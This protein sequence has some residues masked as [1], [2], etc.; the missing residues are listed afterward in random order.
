MPKRAEF[1]RSFAKIADWYER[2]GH[3]VNDPRVQAQ[4]AAESYVE[5]NRAILMNDNMVTTG[6]TAILNHFKRQDNA[7]AAAF[8]LMTEVEFPIVKVATNFADEVA[9]YTAGGLRAIP[10]LTKAALKGIDA[11]SPKEADFIMRNLKKN[12]LSA[13]LASAVFS[14]VLKITFAGNYQRGEKRDSTE[15]KAGEWAINGVKMPTAIGHIPIFESMQVYQTAFNAAEASRL[16]GDSQAANITAGIGQGA[17]SDLEHIPFVGTTTKDAESFATPEGRQKWFTKLTVSLLVPP[18]SSSVAR[19][20]DNDTPRQPR[21]SKEL[22]EN[23]IPGVRQNIPI[24]EGKVKGEIIDRMRKGLDLTEYQQ[25]L[26]DSMSVEKQDSIE[27]ESQLTPRQAAF[28][29]EKSIDKVIKIWGRLSDS[30]RDD[31]RDIYENKINVHMLKVD[32]DKVEE[33]NDK[34]DAAEDRRNP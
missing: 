11:L 26:Y 20:F 34:I 28:E 27:K 2:N 31:L 23:V 29:H 25:E 14:G 6:Y 16:K 13:L 7:G 33:L 32:D 10:G 1:F 15:L 9:S 12:T 22:L 18:D 19:Y 30:E 3:D 4:I 24:N 8:A 21:S 5:A 17:Y